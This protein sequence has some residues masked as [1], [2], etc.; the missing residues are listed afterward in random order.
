MSVAIDPFASLRGWGCAV[1]LGGREYAL[2]PA[3]AVEWLPILMTD[4]MDISAIIPG[5]LSDTDADELEAALID[6]EVMMPDIE[7]VCQEVI[8]LAAGRE[9][10]WACNLLASVAVMWM[11]VFGALVRQGVD[12]GRLPLGAVL[13]AMYSELA[14]RMDKQHLQDF[15]RQL[16]IA[17]SGVVPV[18]DEEREAMNFVALMNSGV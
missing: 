18:I 7:G 15:D 1:E 12:V 8:T 13:D 9:W 4:P 5:M 11:T 17:P 6:G 10:W 3:L 2:R 16:N 14:S